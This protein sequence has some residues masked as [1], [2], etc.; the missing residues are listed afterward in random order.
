MAAL[1][2]ESGVARPVDVLRHEDSPRPW[3]SVSSVP[4]SSCR[5]TSLTGRRRTS[6]RR[7]CTSSST[8]VVTT[9]PCSSPRASSAP[10]TGSIRSC[11][12]R[13]RRLRLE[14]ERAC[15][16][17]VVVRRRAPSTPSSWC[18]LAER[19]AHAHAQPALA[20]A[21]RSDLGIRVT[22]ILDAAQRR[23]R[24]SVRSVAAVSL[25]MLAVVAAMAP[26]R[27]VSVPSV[28]RDTRASGEAGAAARGPDADQ[29]TVARAGGRN[30]ARAIDRALYE[31]AA[32]GDL[33]QVTELLG[34]G[35]NVNAAIEGDGNPLIGAARAGK[36]DVV[37]L[38]LDHGADVDGAVA[39][40]GNALIMAAREGD[41]G[42]V[43]LL[44]DRGA[45]IDLHRSPRRERAHSGERQRP[46]GGRAARSSAGAP[47]STR[48]P[49]PARAT[50]AARWRTP[51]VMARARPPRRRRSGSRRGR[52]ARLIWRRSTGPQGPMVRR[53]ATG[54]GPC[55]TYLGPWTYGP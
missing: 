11:G 28:A 5:P 25:V 54:P 55:R 32:E 43:A 46:P 7:C 31:A 38:L 49:G 36:A 10:R 44:L 45:S 6:G 14:A 39:G 29:L 2:A 42:V 33:D 12:S 16:D 4:P 34:A 21:R 15:D 52:R 20:M 23:G 35:A 30:R 48:V 40:D 9:W 17:A 1:A 41:T 24:A 18:V 47:T 19:L 8:S 53:S 37:R 3:P 27:A 26:L 13:W 51:L 50:A 22:A